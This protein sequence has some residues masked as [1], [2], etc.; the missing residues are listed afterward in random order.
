[1]LLAVLEV[2]DHPNLEQLSES[3][4]G[5]AAFLLCDLF[6]MHPVASHHWVDGVIVDTATIQAGRLV[7]ID[8]RAWCADHRTQWLVPLEIRCAFDDE[9][10]VKKQLQ[11]PSDDT[12]RL[13]AKQG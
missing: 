12:V 8:G 7:V 5:A 4:G 6:Q 3:F 2:G 11:P 13:R 1:L 10:S 9:R